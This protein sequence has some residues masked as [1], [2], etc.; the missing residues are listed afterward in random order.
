MFGWVKMDGVETSQWFAKAS[1]RTMVMEEDKQ[2]E[3]TVS[4]GPTFSDTASDDVESLQLQVLKIRK[5][6]S[7]A[8][9]ELE[10]VILQL[11]KMSVTHA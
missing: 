10:F 9:T 7:T 4:E 6:L 11:E 5:L 8:Q 2:P 1:I 3:A